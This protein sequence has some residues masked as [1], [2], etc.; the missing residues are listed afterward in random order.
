M[1][2]RIF[3]LL[4]AAAL[5]F[6]PACRT[7]R[8]ESYEIAADTQHPLT[9]RVFS[10][11]ADGPAVYIVGG[12]HGD[13]EAGW[14]AAEDLGAAKITAGTL[15]LLSP[16]N[17]FGA[18]NGTR[19]MADGRDLNRN[20]PGGDDGWDTSKTAMAIYQD[21]AEKRPALVIDLHEAEG[22]GAWDDLRDSIIVSDVSRCAD[23]VLGLLTAAESGELPVKD[24]TLYGSPTKGSLNQAVADGLGIPVITVET[25]QT[26]M[27][28]TRMQKQ[29]RIVEYVLAFYGLC[30][31]E[32]EA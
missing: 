18:E 9:V 22:D 25:N 20:F 1:R 31:G 21:I 8:A 19:F 7:R 16:A 10:G 30:A 27:L 3:S 5:L 17:P 15:Y 26:E 28:E 11:A 2:V 6:V 13:E 12:I 23:L 4:L 24:L 32:G 14:R 29:A